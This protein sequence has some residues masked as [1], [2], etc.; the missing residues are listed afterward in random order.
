MPR[1]EPCVGGVGN[2]PAGARCD[3]YVLFDNQRDFY[4]DVSCIAVGTGAMRRKCRTHL[5]AGVGARLREAEKKK[6]YV[7]A[8]DALS[9]QLNRMNPSKFYPFV[10]ESGGRMG[11]D[12]LAF[13]DEILEL[14]FAGDKSKISVARHALMTKII[15]TFDRIQF[16]RMRKFF[17]AMSCR[18]DRRMRQ[19][20]LH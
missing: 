18:M 3:I 15:S 9:A 16:W 19:A 6:K 8:I 1:I 14:S 4:L 2:L 11:P 5:F 7:R 13:I 12:T 20:L 10:L 17:E